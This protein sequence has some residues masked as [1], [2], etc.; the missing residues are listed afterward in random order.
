MYLAGLQPSRL[1]TAEQRRRERM[2]GR[3]IRNRGSRVIA[4][5]A[6]VTAALVALAAAATTN[7]QS[8]RA[9]ANEPQAIEPPTSFGIDP[10]KGTCPKAEPEKLPPDALAGATVAALDQVP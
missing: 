2:L 1:K 4:I 6:V 10:M 5:V 3:A 8:D 7:Q 9:S